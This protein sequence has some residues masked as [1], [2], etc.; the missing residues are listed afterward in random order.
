MMQNSLLKSSTYRLQVLVMLQGQSEGFIACGGYGP[1]CMYCMSHHQP[2]LFIG[3]GTARCEVY[4]SVATL[5]GKSEV[6]GAAAG[7]KGLVM[8]DISGGKE[9]IRI[10][11]FNSID[12]EGPPA[13]LQYIR[14]ATHVGVVPV[15]CLHSMQPPACCT[16][17]CRQAVSSDPLV[18]L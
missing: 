16:V 6:F 15:F 2:I 12:D 8:L 18:M 14:C 7:Q 5:L 4:V 10:P 9:R 1:F 11:V 13:D 3:S 17:L